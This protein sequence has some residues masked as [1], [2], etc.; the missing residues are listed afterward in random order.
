MKPIDLH[1]HS[2]KSDGSNS[3]EQLIDLA[4]KKQ[5]SAFALTDHDTTE[6][7]DQALA[8][9]AKLRTL[10]IKEVPEVI[11][12]IELSTQY[13][14]KDIHLVGLDIDHHAPAF[15]TQLEH[16]IASRIER[17]RKMC[18]NLAQ[19]GIDITY[20]KLVSEFPNS[21]LTRAHYAVYLTKYGYS[22][23]KEDAFHQY[24]G[25]YTPYFV[26]REKITP[27]MGI[28]LILQSGG[29][30]ILAHPALY[31][32]S[33]AHLDNL[34]SQLKEVG[35]IGIE[36]IYSSYNLATERHIRTLASKYDLCISGGSDYHGDAKP[37]LEIGTG[38]GHLFV[39]E[40]LL[41]KLRS[42]L[43]D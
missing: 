23:S 38:Y 31:H 10:G 43:H 8:Y 12:G 19:A 2:N 13:H 21:V 29:I 41:T 24:L 20:E 27:Q 15:L 25:D 6:G 17:N 5:L 42:R 35:L 32:L 39:P 9:A 7:I 3:P 33:D 34:V 37:D 1:V 28:E 14:G 11:P 40:D 26:P 36:A 16:F 30:P 4:L 22:L 18:Q